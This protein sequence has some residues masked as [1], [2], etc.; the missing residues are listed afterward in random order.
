M[1]RTVGTKPSFAAQKRGTSAIG[2]SRR[3]GV[4][5]KPPPVGPNNDPDAWLLRSPVYAETGYLRPSG[6]RKLCVRLTSMQAEASAKAEKSTRENYKLSQEIE[7]LKKEISRLE[8]YERHFKQYQEG[9]KKTLEKSLEDTQTALRSSKRALA[10]STLKTE[11]LTLE[12][13][14]L[15]RE[16]KKLGQS[17]DKLKTLVY[18]SSSSRASTTS[19]KVVW[20]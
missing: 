19:T 12:V 6:R 14:R 15:T 16:N 17:Y 18:G 13:E 3:G 5:G 1:R 2:R 4:P 9:E 10:D 11:S 20:G 7:E 8:K